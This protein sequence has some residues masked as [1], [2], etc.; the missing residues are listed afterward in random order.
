MK[1]RRLLDIV[2][3]V[4]GV[5]S[6]AACTM[7][8]R[9]VGS[10][11]KN[12]LFLM[13]D[14]SNKS[15]TSSNY[16]SY[17]IKGTCQRTGE[18][19]QIEFPSVGSYVTPCLSD[20]TF[21]LMVDLGGIS[22]GV[23]A[24]VAKQEESA[25]KVTSLD[26]KTITVDLTAPT[27]TVDNPD[28]RQNYA[29]SSL[30][31]NYPLA[32]NCS[33]P[34][35]TVKVA[36]SLTQSYMAL[37]S[38]GNRWEVRLDLSAETASSIDFY[39]QHFDSAGNVSATISTN[40][41]YPQWQKI[42]PTITAT[43]VASVRTIAQYGDSGRFLLT[44][45]LR[46]DDL[47]DFGIVNFNNTGLSRLNPLSAQWAVDSSKPILPVP[48]LGRALYTRSTIGRAQLRE[49]HSVKIDGTDDKVLMGP[50]VANPVGGVTTYALT[51]NQDFVIALGD[52]E[53]T[54]N[55]FNLYAINTATGAT[56][57]LSGNMVAG[58][59]VRDFLITPN[60]E[61]V[62]FRAD[63]NTDEIVEIYS[64]KIDGT[65]LRRLGPALAAGKSAYVGYKIS[66]DSKWV[67]FREN[68]TYAVG[69]N[70]GMMVVSLENGDAI[71]LVGTGTGGFVEN[72]SFS[73]DSK[74][75]AYRIDRTMAGC[76]ALEAY[77][78]QTRTETELSVPCANV[79]MDVMSY[80]WSNDSSKMGYGLATA[81]GYYDLY[82]SNI[83]G[84]N[85]LK[86]TASTTLRN[87]VYGGYKDKTIL[88]TPDNKTIVFL[89]DFSGVVRAST[90]DMKFDMYSIKADGSGSRV[91]L[92]PNS[93]GNVIRD[94]PII[95]ISPS[96]DRVAFVAD[97]EVDTKYE[98][99][100]A[101]VD[102]S[103]I[104][105]LNPPLL[106]SQGSLQTG[107]QGYFFDWPRNTVAFL[108]DAAIDNVNGAYLASLSLPAP[109]LSSISL[110]SV[111][112]GD[113][114][115]DV[116]SA[117]GS[118]VLIRLNPTTDAEMHLYVVDADGSNFRRVT[119]DYP[120]GGGT[121]R[122][123]TITSDGSKILYIADQDTAGVEEL[124]VVDT[125]GG[126]PVKVSATITAVG[127]NV[128]QYKLN[129]ATGKIVYQGDLVTDSV[130]DLYAVNLDG[131]GHTKL[132]P[133]YG[134]KTTIYE[135]EFAPN[136]AYVVLRWDNRTIDK[137][138]VDKIAIGGGAPVALNAAIAAASDLSGIAISP[139]SAWVCYFG[140][141]AVPRRGDARVVNAA[142][143]ATNYL[144]DV[145]IDTVQMVTDCDFTPDSEY[146]ILK[147]DWYTDG[148]VAMKTFKIATQ[149]LTVLNSTLPATSN[150]SWSQALVEGANK[151]L[152]T[153]S[154]SSPEIY[155]IYSAN[156]DG[157][158]V[159]KIS[160]TPYAGGMVNANNGQ[161]VR[162]LEDADK[163]IVYSGLIETLGKWDLFAVK[164]DGTQ[165]RKLV[166]LPSYAD[167][168]D[169]SVS[170]I[171]N[172]VFFRSDYTK[173]GVMSVYSVNTDG[174]GLKNYMP[175]LTGNS[176]VWYV[177]AVTTSHVLFV[178]D[179]YQSQVL[180]LFI[181]TL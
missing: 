135:W 94:Y 146:V 176:G 24:I 180:E 143:P 43:G 5:Y 34:F 132:T 179:A 149:T 30:R 121:V 104:K 91:L 101:A 62:V 102:G 115:S 160:Q 99:Y 70:T 178:S 4:L 40:I 113:V 20:Q 105:K 59:D 112:S 64:V 27:V 158:D 171:S 76:Y 79:N 124:Y 42:S 75:V 56:T 7:D 177:Q 65:N 11:S 61:E 126:A 114:V 147:G 58:G 6:L 172:K 80:A 14:E 181:D 31:G 174:T 130:M 28:N 167:I 2:V 93:N 145:G 100:L 51:P 63:K 29:L 136:G 127:G 111:V 128:T 67:L 10:S 9:L 15:I 107:S 25:E 54:D 150:T 36:T 139:D 155:E 50:T 164:W 48:K 41:S 120:S 92:T 83:D 22:E 38:A 21:S 162:I 60:G 108:A 18:D 165:K 72:G 140:G 95:E 77:N 1:V 156:Y 122:G 88:F 161:A 97:L 81:S 157:T 129:E 142:T 163:T 109:T 166:T 39:I 68:Q 74:Y 86:L 151:R 153:L 84:S 87:G 170:P 12:H 19:V 119:K 96:G 133:A 144:I 33:E 116:A 17:I 134:H 125:A 103:L 118:K 89:A 168:Y 175:G 123:W 138:E 78:L 47:I 13:I 73:P 82:V 137:I 8:A 52:I 154:E 35:N 46:N 90:S 141:M 85:R 173:D 53:A 57:K 23:Y 37:C 152:I 49:L 44:V 69:A 3:V 110:P 131:S 71:S 117:N 32:G 66:P 148:K 45:P 16:R 106:P 98:M 169:F 55:E 159:R 26:T